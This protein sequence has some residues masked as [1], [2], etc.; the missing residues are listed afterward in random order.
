MMSSSRMC[1]QILPVQLEF[2]AGVLAEQH[3]VAGL[4]AH[5]DELA[6]VVGLAGAAVDHFALRGLLGGG[7]G[8]DDAAGGLP[9]FFETFDD[10][11]IVQGTNLHG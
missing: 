1:R 8:D 2:L 3:L 10:H 6:V 11:A 5:R 7:V 9:L 4:D